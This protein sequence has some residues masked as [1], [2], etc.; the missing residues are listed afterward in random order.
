MTDPPPVLVVLGE[1]GID[2]VASFA[3]EGVF[4]RRFYA[5][6][7]GETAPLAAPRGLPGDVVRLEATTLDGA[8]RE[9]R[10]RAPE[11]PVL[12]VYAGERLAGSLRPGDSD[13]SSRAERASSSRVPLDLSIRIAGKS[14][15]H[16]TWF[17]GRRAAWAPAPGAP[18]VAPAI[19]AT[20]DPGD[21]SAIL[22]FL[23]RDALAAAAPRGPV[24]AARLLADPL[25]TTLRVAL[26][27][28][29]RDGFRGFLVAALHGL[30]RLIV[31]AR[32]WQAS[33]S[34]ARGATR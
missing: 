5:S 15:R 14:T 25:V 1:P 29:L 31:L 20:R 27:G 30:H 16:S 13:G 28:G 32:A 2:P 33:E 23:V 7:E 21:L 24:G 26:S 11:A 9:A 19:R 12:L 8:L 18:R 10:G 3:A 17:R 34:G 6:P 22:A 4:S